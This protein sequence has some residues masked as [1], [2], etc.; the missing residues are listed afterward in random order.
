MMLQRANQDPQVEVRGKQVLLTL[1]ETSLCQRLLV[2]YS[3]LSNRMT[4]LP[5]HLCVIKRS[6]FP[7][8]LAARCDHVT[9]FVA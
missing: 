3:S 8:Y 7:V 5:G 4:V 6:H 1:S 2:A 9:K